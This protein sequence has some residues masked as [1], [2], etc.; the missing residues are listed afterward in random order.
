MQVYPLLFGP[1]PDLDGKLGFLRKQEPWSRLGSNPL[2][3][4]EV[5][6]LSLGDQWKKRLF[7][8]YTC[9]P[10]LCGVHGEAEAG[11]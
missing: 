8:S 1:L 6:G 5:R 3:Q 10:R 7:C 4:M 9:I 11:W 2:L